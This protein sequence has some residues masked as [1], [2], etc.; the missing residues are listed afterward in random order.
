MS[1]NYTAEAPHPV[2]AGTPGLNA[3]ELFG[4]I[5]AV[6]SAVLCAALSFGFVI[7]IHPDTSTD[8]DLPAIVLWTFAFFAPLA[9]AIWA[10]VAQPD[11]LVDSAFHRV[12]SD[13][14]RGRAN[15][16]PVSAASLSRS[17]A[18]RRHQRRPVRLAA[19]GFGAAGIV[20]S[21]PVAL[22][23][24]EHVGAVLRRSWGPVCMV[25]RNNRAGSLA[26]RDGGRRATLLHD[27]PDRFRGA[28]STGRKLVRSVWIEAACPGHADGRRCARKPLEQPSFASC[29]E[30]H[31][32]RERR[33]SWRDD[34]ALVASTATLYRSRAEHRF[35]SLRG[36][37]H[38]SDARLMH[39]RGAFRSSFADLFA[40]N[41][42]HPMRSIGSTSQRWGSPTSK[43]QHSYL[44]ANSR[45]AASRATASRSGSCNRA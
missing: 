9:L 39:R 18:L 19:S 36:H 24:E 40:R 22:L 38:S 13:P 17:S 14:R 16:G 7:T 42:R 26:G 43:I 4:T 25:V 23:P 28:L 20:R 37:R 30:P 1:S 15:S 8:W 10:I 11:A 12:S 27:R 5:R 35:R 29:A 33:R 41:R 34:L 3:K 32:S 31:W 21:R 45:T 2:T 6:A 44:A